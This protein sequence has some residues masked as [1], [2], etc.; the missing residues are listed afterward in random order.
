MLLLVKSF[1]RDEMLEIGLLSSNTS[2]LYTDSGVLLLLQSDAAYKNFAL[3]TVSKYILLSRKLC[4]MY[5]DYALCIWYDMGT[6]FNSV[7]EYWLFIMFIGSCPKCM[8]PKNMA[9]YTA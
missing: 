2:S 9:N 5:S 1:I 7:E 6:M 3:L 8:T 4:A